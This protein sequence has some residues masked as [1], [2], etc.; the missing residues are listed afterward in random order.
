MSAE[1]SCSEVPAKKVY[2]FIRSKRQLLPFFVCFG[3]ESGREVGGE[4]NEIISILP[5]PDNPTSVF[6]SSVG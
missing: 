5:S 6:W 3:E 2:L 1:T 4:Y